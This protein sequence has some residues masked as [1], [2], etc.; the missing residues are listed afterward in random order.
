MQHKILVIVMAFRMKMMCWHCGI[1][2]STAA[3]QNEDDSSDSDDG[4]N[5][6]DS[7]WW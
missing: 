6:G 2:V 4:D 3:S 5:G 1:V 7:V